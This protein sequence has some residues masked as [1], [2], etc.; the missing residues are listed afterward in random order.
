MLLTPHPEQLRA[1]SGLA[2]NHYALGNFRPAEVGNFQPALT[3][4]ARPTGLSL[5]P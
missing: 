2:Y 4:G 1:G 5:H 3:E